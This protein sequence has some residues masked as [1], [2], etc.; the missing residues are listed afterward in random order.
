[1]E[2]KVIEKEAGVVRMNSENTSEFPFYGR[3][4]P[5]CRCIL[6]LSCEDV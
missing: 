2:T 6:E 4:Y 3:H 5:F 1:M